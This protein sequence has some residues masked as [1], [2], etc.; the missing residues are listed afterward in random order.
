MTG[1]ML[2]THGPAS[3]SPATFDSAASFDADTRVGR[4]RPCMHADLV[5]LDG[6]VLAGGDLLAV[7][8]AR[9]IVGG[10]TVFEKETTETHA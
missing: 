6:D 4:V 9:T 3:P 10:N 5:M 8:V 2:A 7:S 1:S